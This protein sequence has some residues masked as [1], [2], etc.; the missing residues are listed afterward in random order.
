MRVIAMQCQTALT[1]STALLFNTPRFAATSHAGGSLVITQQ[2]H[3]TGAG[4]ALLQ[5]EDAAQ[6]A[7]AIETL[8]ELP[9]DTGE[10]IFDGLCA[11]HS[12]TH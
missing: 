12:F 2:S 11:E 7:D 5:G 4:S 6:F 10:A 9:T 1:P 3:G 8:S